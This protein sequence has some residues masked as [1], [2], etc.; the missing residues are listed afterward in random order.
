MGLGFYSFI[1]IIIS[2]VL[3]FIMFGIGL[4]L[5]PQNFRDIAI[6]PKS[7]I[8]GLSAQM[9]ALPLIAFLIANISNLPIPY[10]IGLILLASCPGGTT[11][12]FITYLFKG[13]VALAITLT[14]IN[15]I[16]T[17]VSIPF[18]TNLALQYYYG[19]GTI[20]HLPF[21][22]TVVQIFVV[23]IVPA[24]LGVIYKYFN[25]AT[26]VKL[27]KPLKYILIIALA[28][29][30]I[31][32]IFASQKSGGTGITW[33]EFREILP[34]ALGLNIACA[35]AG[36]LTGAITKLG[37]RNSYTISIE[38]AVHNTTLAFLIAGALLQNQDMVK[39]SLVYSMF[40]FW[41][42]L[43]FSLAVKKINK[44]RMTEEFN[45]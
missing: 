3:A 28:V 29:V 43:L 39:P 42:A 25:P 23:T 22:E 15:S 31:V 9:I 14:A 36:Y 45:D 13:N 24:A 1:D 5:T 4:S 20:I 16:L 40:S 26:A 44:S 8:I 12:G 17:L 37:S 21:F 11:A 27:Q 34:W 38:A 7:I 10:K 6:H 19:K 32:K 18:I 35:L 2:C 30:F 41:T 33:D